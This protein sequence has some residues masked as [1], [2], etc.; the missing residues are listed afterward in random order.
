MVL[1]AS[2]WCFRIPKGVQLGDPLYKWMEHDLILAEGRK[3]GT[4]GLSSR[5]VETKGDIDIGEVGGWGLLEYLLCVLQAC[6][7]FPSRH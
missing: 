6:G 5:S 7:A 3:K 4:I 1:C 2:D